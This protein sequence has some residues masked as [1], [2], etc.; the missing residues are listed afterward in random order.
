MSRQPL[1]S[2]VTPSYNQGGF[3]EDTLLSVKNQ[4]YPNIEHIIVDGGSTDN[5]LEVLRKYEGTYDMRWISEPDEGQS[6]AVNKGFRLA[7]G[8]IIGWINSSDG[9]FDVGAVGYAVKSFSKYEDAD[10]LYGN[11]AKIDEN[12]SI[13]YIIRT[14]RFSHDFLRK[15]NFL[16]Q[17]AVFFRRNVIEAFQ[18]NPGLEIAMDYDFWLRI[19]TKHGFRH[20]NRVFAVDRIHSERKVVAMRD[21]MIA[22]FKRI[23]EEHGQLTL[24]DRIYRLGLGWIGSISGSIEVL[25]PN[26]KYKFAFELKADDTLSILF[27]RLI[28]RLSR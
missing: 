3:I 26:N 21:V 16:R 15:S 13:L 25:W 23:S 19:A 27:R 8:E 2:I 1:V 22:E 6:D 14:R 28:P 4:D 7:R 9:Y 24:V 10:V 11:I 20:I 17:P 5:T 12:N 18:L